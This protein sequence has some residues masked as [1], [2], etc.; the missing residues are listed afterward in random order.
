MDFVRT[1]CEH[2][3][4]IDDLIHKDERFESIIEK[5][6]VKTGEIIRITASASNLGIYAEI[7]K[8]RGY[9]S[10]SFKRLYNHVNDSI[11]HQNKNMTFSE[12]KS[13]LD[14]INENLIN[15]KLLNISSIR[16]RFNLLVN[17]SA[18]EIVNKN[19]LLHKKNYYNHNKMDKIKRNYKS[20]EYENFSIKI[21]VL[22]FKKKPSDFLSIELNMKKKEFKDESI[23]QLFDLNSKEVN[24]LLHTN[25]IKRFNELTIVDSML[26]QN[27]FGNEDIEFIKQCMT[28]G[29]WT[30]ISKI[31]SRQTCSVKW[32]KFIN[33]IEK[34]GLNNTK[35]GLVKSL[36]K[37]FEELNNN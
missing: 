4:L 14:Y 17:N 32:H 25:L 5:T 36:E 19:L 3:S 1:Y 26:E 9:L 12:L 8:Y 21:F 16:I 23:N 6:D 33:L 10:F 18:Q 15:T 22:E 37:E 20:F 7:D 31:Y 2:I 29:Y 30:G 28:Y 35:A 11:I 34:Y 27:T 24:M 13:C